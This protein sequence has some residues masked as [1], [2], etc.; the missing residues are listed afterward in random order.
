MMRLMSD[1]GPFQEPSKVFIPPLPHYIYL[2]SECFFRVPD[3]VLTAR[4]KLFVNRPE[5]GKI[6]LLTGRPQNSDL[7][8]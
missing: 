3:P 5:S 8:F 2:A 7:D 4:G 1:P 6:T